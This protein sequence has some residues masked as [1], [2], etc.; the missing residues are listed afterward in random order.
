MLGSVAPATRPRPVTKPE[1]QPPAP[2]TTS[3]RILVAAMVLLVA[4]CAALVAAQQ[5]GRAEDIQWRI[6]WDWLALAVGG[7]ALLHLSHAE[8]WRRI[9]ARLH[10]GLAPH[11]AWS[12]WL[13]STPARYVP[14]SLLMP[15]LRV[16]MLWGV[17]VPRRCSL[18]AVIHE[19][20]L[21]FTG[22]LVLSAYFV[23]SLPALSN[24]PLRFAVLLLPLLALVA[25]SHRVFAPLATFALRRLGHD[26][27]QTAVTMDTAHSVLFLLGYVGSFLLAGLS[28]FALVRTLVPVSLDAIPTVVMSF[29]VGYN[30][31]LLAPVLPGGVGAR[32]AGLTAA[33]ATVISAGAALAVA[34]ALRILQLVIELVCAAIATYIRRT[35]PEN[36]NPP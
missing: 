31:A 35:L 8:L 10:P 22:A 34:I 30:A 11:A 17:G 4:S 1:Q 13:M 33:L 23:V 3:R 9:L 15:F 7:F 25:L 27:A 6:A 5:L 26:R 16:S 36:A 28:L 14:T 19:L 18:S 12:V 32:E 24:Q 29:A 2:Q 21:S 20:A